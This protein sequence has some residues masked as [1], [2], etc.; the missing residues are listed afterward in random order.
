MSLK[1]AEIPVIAEKSRIAGVSCC[2]EVSL[3]EL[4]SR[5]P[6]LSK[7][8]QGALWIPGETVVDPWLTAI[9]LAHDARK[10]GAMVT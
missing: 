6:G 8:A 10:K 7:H 4:Y 5:E 9:S 2:V 3:S 1:A